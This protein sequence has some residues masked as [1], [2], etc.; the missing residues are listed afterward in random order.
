MPSRP[1]KPGTIYTYQR[2]L[3]SRARDSLAESPTVMYR[4]LSSQSYNLT[5]Y[6]MLRK[7][8]ES[9]FVTEPWQLFSDCAVGFSVQDVGSRCLVLV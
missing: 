1:D 9:A 4:V 2:D 3:L 6:Y 8:A 7:H 5:C